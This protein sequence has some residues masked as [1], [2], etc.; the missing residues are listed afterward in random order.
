MSKAE[1]G[2]DAAQFKFDPLPKQK[3]F[4]ESTAG[5]VLLSGSFGAGKSRVGC[6]KGYLLNM[7]YPGNRGL[8][9]RKHFSDVRTS[10]IQQTLL[11]EV[12]PESH[13]P[14]NGHN[15]GNHEISHR[16]GQTDD[17]GDPVL[18]EIHYHGL[19][20]GSNTS[21]DDLPRKIGSTAYGW[22]F[23]DEGTELTEGE[24]AQLQGRLRYKGKRQAGKFYKVPIRQI[25]SAT[26][27]ESPNHW[28]YKEFFE[29]E[30]GHAIKMNVQENP[31]VPDEYVERMRR[32]LSGI[33]YERYFEGKWVGS[34]G[35]I[36]DEY[37]PE[38][39]VI[40]PS[41]LPDGWEVANGRHYD[42]EEFENTVFTSPPSD[43]RVYRTIDFGY[44]NPFV[45]LWIARSPD[46]TLYVFRQIYKSNELV[47]DLATEIQQYTNHDWVV[48]QTYADHDAESHE[49]LKRNGVYASNATKDVAA[50]IQEVKTKF[51]TDQRGEAQLYFVRG[52]R[53]HPPDSNLVIDDK[54]TKMRDEILDYKWRDSDQEDRPRK[55]DDHGVDALRYA[56]YTMEESN[57]MSQEQM[58]EWEDVLNSGF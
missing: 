25:F 4:I 18:S 17:N 34:E 12:I 6:E 13:I 49:V 11:E 20:S 32:N 36:Y 46:D 57:S 52:S 7:M 56:I 50:G 30:N 23:V 38:I 35:I 27:P 15:K 14:E 9:V 1:V 53:I 54:P 3:E 8:I 55:V 48:E 31:Y 47:E 39:H 29:R 40:E 19:D 43:Y 2:E 26:N 44:R 16:T 21:D 22:I 45:C 51:D 28:M 42:N 37:D 33:Y 58:E 5:Q 41:D 10:T 24:W